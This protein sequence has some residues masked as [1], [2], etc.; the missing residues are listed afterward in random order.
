MDNLPRH[1]SLL[2]RLILFFFADVTLTLVRPDI[3]LMYG[4]SSR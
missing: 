3:D 4:N 2:V 1:T